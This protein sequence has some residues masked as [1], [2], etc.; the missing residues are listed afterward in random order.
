M[1]FSYE[2]SQSFISLNNDCIRDMFWGLPG[3]QGTIED[4]VFNYKKN[5]TQN[6]TIDRAITLLNK[7][8][9]NDGFALVGCP[10]IEEIESYK[11]GKLIGTIWAFD[12]IM[13]CLAQSNEYLEG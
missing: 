10:I 13:F 7:L 5:T 11:E 4:V 3:E 9:V 2:K 6:M 8:M 12:Y 1:S